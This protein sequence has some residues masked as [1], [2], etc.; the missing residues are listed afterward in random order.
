MEYDKDKVDD[1]TLALMYL[2]T[3]KFDNDLPG[4][5]TWKSF[6]WDTL[7]RLY[8]KGFISDPKNKNKS[9]RMTKEAYEKA[10]ALFDEMFRKKN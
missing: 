2:V 8:E 4:F 9:V 10:E 1:V 5:S 6:D 3:F 7:N